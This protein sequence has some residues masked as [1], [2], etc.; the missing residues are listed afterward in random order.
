MGIAGQG[1][2][3]SLVLT[4]TPCLSILCARAMKHHMPR[5]LTILAL[6]AL[7]VHESP[8][9]SGVVLCYGADGHVAAERAQ[10]GTCDSRPAPAGHVPQEPMVGISPD[11]HCG[12]CGDVPL[13]RIAARASRA[14][15]SHPSLATVSLPWHLAV[16]SLRS[17]SLGSGPEAAA[18]SPTLASLLTVVLLT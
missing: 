1:V 6:A 7:M 11:A 14:A 13:L 8:G 5:A 16:P 18:M 3:G 9:A 4:G 12:P 2:I 15:P 10:N 17:P